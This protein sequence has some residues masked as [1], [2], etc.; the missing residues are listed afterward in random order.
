VE[1]GTSIACQTVSATGGLLAR[2]DF[3]LG[4]EAGFIRL[5]DFPAPVLL[6]DTYE[7]PVPGTR[8]VLVIRPLLEAVTRNGPLPALTL[9][10]RLDAVTRIGPKLFDLRNLKPI[11]PP[12]SLAIGADHLSRLLASGPRHNPP[13]AEPGT[14]VGRAPQSLILHVK[15][16]YDLLW[17]DA[18]I[19]AVIGLLRRV[20]KVRS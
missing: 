9:R 17:C 10:P 12:V 19:Q 7:S 14:V 8:T 16:K 6:V 15:C 2:G 3:V 4:A 1:S 11:A 13:C 20:R 5:R 18:F